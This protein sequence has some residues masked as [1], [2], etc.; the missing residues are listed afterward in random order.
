MRILR[1]SKKHCGGH[2][3]RGVICVGSKAMHVTVQG[4]NGVAESGKRSICKGKIFLCV[5]CMQ[6]GGKRGGDV[7]QRGNRL[8]ECGIVLCGEYLST[9]RRVLEC[10]PQ[11]ALAG[12]A[13]RCG[14]SGTGVG[15]RP[16]SRWSRAA[17]LLRACRWRGGV[18]IV[19][20]VSASLPAGGR[21]VPCRW[22]KARADRRL[23]FPV[24]WG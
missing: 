1:G 10:F 21:P 17:G 20:S 13:R 11:G 15:G 7:W 8:A 3:E 22:R 24:G 12:S 23:F 2:G 5:T 18:R 9:C 14:A 16:R 19:D 6:R 4:R